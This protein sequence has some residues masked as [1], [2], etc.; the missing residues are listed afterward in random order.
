MTSH[1]IQHRVG[2]GLHMTKVSQLLLRG[3]YGPVLGAIVVICAVRAFLLYIEEKAY[4][5]N[6]LL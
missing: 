6:L 4:R 3:L 2:G 5:K 1:T